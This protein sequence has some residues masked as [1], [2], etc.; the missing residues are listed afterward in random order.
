VDHETF[1]GRRG[2]RVAALIMY[3]AVGLLPAALFLLV[4]A[5]YTLIWLVLTLPVLVVCI[6][7]ASRY[8]MTLTPQ[9]L[10][11]D[12]AGRRTSMPWQQVERIELAEITESRPGQP[13]PI[14]GGRLIVH[15]RSTPSP[16]GTRSQRRRPRPRLF[17]PR[18]DPS[19]GGLVF[20]T[21]QAADWPALD[22][23]LRRYAGSRYHRS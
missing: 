10:E 4:S 16:L 15:S 13:P 5:S 23:A 12:I 14:G 6:L 21:V 7:L 11:L 2:S 1:D 8:A 20:W 3:G 22:A 18:S 19:S 17:A 9:A